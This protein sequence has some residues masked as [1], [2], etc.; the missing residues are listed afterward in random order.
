MLWFSRFQK[1]LRLDLRTP[2]RI[3]SA[4]K[5]AK[6]LNLD[7]KG[8]E[9]SKRILYM[10]VL[11]ALVLGLT[12]TACGGTTAD[13]PTNNTT[14]NNSADMEE[15]TEA[16]MEEPTEEPMPE[17]TGMDL[18]GTSIV[19]WSVY[20]EGDALNDLINEY[21]TEFNASNEWGITVEHLGQVDYNPL[22]D[23]VN[24]GLTSGDLPNIVQAYTSSFL[25]WDLLG[26]V[27]DLTPYVNDADYG[28]TAEEQAAI[29]PGVAA[30]GLTVDGRRLAYPL[31]QSANVMTYNF[32]WAQELGFDNPPSNTAE[33]KE[34]LCAAAA[35]NASDDN[36]DNDGTG[37][38]VWYPSASNYLSFVYA[39][40]GNELNADQTAYDFTSQPFI[41]VAMYINDLKANGC[42]F[43]TES[44]PNPEQA[45]RL[46]LITL[47]STAGLRY[48]T[49][50]FEDANNDDDWG[51]L[52]FVGPNGETAADAFTQSV[53]VLTSTPEQDLAS[54]L[55]IKYMTTPENQ[56]RWVKASGYLPTQ[57]TTEPL[58]T[59][60]VASEPRFQSAL[61][62]SAAGQA[63][64][65][66][67]PA[68]ASV[69]RAINDAAALLYDPSLDEAGVLTILQQ[70][71]ADAAE[72]VSEVQ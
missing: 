9:M 50:A 28:L 49:A 20:D 35:A 58:L 6:K 21:V 34:Q 7:N 32:T 13:E 22:V 12:L 5:P 4:G 17:D 55:F 14:A 26:A 65:Q 54:W 62:L 15:P 23:K 72:Y 59:D 3:K 19:F 57:S 25:D 52:P 70:L 37:G 31:S 36:P 66:T 24:A 27:T 53:G 42:T 11:L 2:D 16:P 56:A 30:D 44:Y 18:S 51:F 10:V 46:A 47:S 40:G 64:P 33:L 69:R 8:E 71:N 29:Y 61:D 67:F 43:E 68:W 63:E 45:Q 48:Y 41:D 60:Y 38:M 1:I 39:Y